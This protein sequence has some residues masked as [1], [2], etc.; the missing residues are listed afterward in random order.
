YALLFFAGWSLARGANLQKFWFKRDPTAKAFGLLDP[1]A[2]SGGGRH[3]PA[4]GLGRRPPR[5]RGRLL[6]PLSPYQL[7]GRDPDGERPDAVSRISAVSRTLAVSA[8]LRGAVGA[9][10]ERR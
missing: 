2:I 8:L 1:R 5:A 9:A 10:R 3:V 7:L 4:G 6:G